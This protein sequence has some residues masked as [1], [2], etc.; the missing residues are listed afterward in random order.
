M[1]RFIFS[2]ILVGVYAIGFGQDEEFYYW[3]KGERQSLQLKPDKTFLLLNHQINKEALSSKLQID[4]MNVDPV[5]K[6]Q[7]GG[8]QNHKHARF[9]DSYW[10]IVKTESKKLDLYIPE[11][12]Y[13]G[14]FFEG[15][16][17]EEVGLSHLFYVKLHQQRDIEK[18][19]S[20]ANQ[21]QI[22]I[23]HNNNF[24]PLW[25]TLA[26]DRSSTGNALQMANLFYETGIFAAAEPDLMATIFSNGNE[27]RP[28]TRRENSLKIAP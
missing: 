6:V 10:T 15:E 25:Y 16:K 3:Y 23:L 12:A 11:I 27:K 13:H 19:E 21:H 17:G 1:K 22:E 7:L 14:P 28:Q 24:R 2:V 9:R 4:K 8:S 26:C 20:L 5:R 18:L